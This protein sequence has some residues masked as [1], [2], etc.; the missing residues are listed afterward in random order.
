MA[1]HIKGAV[2]VDIGDASERVFY[3]IVFVG[4]RRN[5]LEPGIVDEHIDATKRRKRCLNGSTV[6]DIAFERRDPAAEA[7][8]HLAG[9]L[10]N[11]TAGGK[12]C[13]LCP[14]GGK[15]FRDRAADA[16]AGARHQHVFAGKIVSDTTH[17]LSLSWRA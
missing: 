2:G 12:N 17:G 15:T 13:D 6:G 4:H 7:F 14:G 8:R 10:V 11:S 3:A 16:A 1:G 9:G 5:A